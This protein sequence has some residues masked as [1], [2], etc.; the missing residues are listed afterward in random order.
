MEGTYR[1]AV[2][3]ATGQVGRLMLRILEE[4]RFPARELV[5][6]AS[7]RSAGAELNGYGVIQGLSDESIAGFDLA[8]FSAGGS[9]SGE[10]APRFAKAGAVVVDNS[11]RWRMHDDVPLVVSEVNPDAL[12]EHHGIIANPNCSTM[13]MVVALKP[14]HDTA[15]IERLVI[16]TYQAVSGTGKRAVE[17]LATQAEAVLASRRG[18]GEPE[19]EPDVYKHPIAFNALPEAGSFAQGDDHTD[20]ERKLMNETRKILGDSAIAVSATCVRVPVFVGHSE[21][22]NVQTRD[23]LSPAQARALLDAAPGV[24]VIDD[25]T[26]ARYPLATLA[27]GRDDVFVGRIRRD[28]GHERA[29]DMWIVADNL[30][31]GAAT[32]AVQIAELLHQRGL[33]GV[34]TEQAVA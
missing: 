31:K 3:G 17:E 28:P 30:R 6:F 10:W 20:E 7:A 16:C 22:V 14:L 12:A 23:P 34:A 21:A 25:P 33:I 27:E 29:L 5:P 13:Q 19:L 4:R 9:V 15:G 32:N 2:V 24:S 8:L 18:G 26:A 1:V 11:S